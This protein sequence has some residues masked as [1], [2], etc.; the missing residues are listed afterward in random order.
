[1]AAAEKEEWCGVKNIFVEA[2]TTPI[3]VLDFELS[4]GLKK[5]EANISVSFLVHISALY[6][7]CRNR[8]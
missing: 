6:H 8:K 7:P 3:L 2:K 4:A 1:M 5:A